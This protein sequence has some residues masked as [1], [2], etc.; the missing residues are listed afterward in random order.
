MPR[1]M[2][3]VDSLALPDSGRVAQVSKYVWKNPVGLS[4]LF[5]PGTDHL[6]WAARPVVRDRIASVTALVRFVLAGPGA[7]IRTLS[8]CVEAL[9]CMA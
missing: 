7:V 6:V 1:E 4:G 3:Y 5:V 8:S 2:C 9:G